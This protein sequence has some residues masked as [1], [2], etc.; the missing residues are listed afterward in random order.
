MNVWS[1][2][3]RVSEVSVSHLDYVRFCLSLVRL[4]VFLAL[5]LVAE[6]AS[7]R[8]SELS[9]LRLPWWS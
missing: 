7:K 4:N 8:G 2:V 1:A 9:P 5:P 3:Q 6:K